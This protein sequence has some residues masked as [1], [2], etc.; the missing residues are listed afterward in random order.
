M[1]ARDGYKDDVNCGLGTDTAYA[2]KLDRVNEDCENVVPGEP[3]P[4][5]PRRR[6]RVLLHCGP[7]QGHKEEAVASYPAS[8]PRYPRGP[9]A[10]DFAPVNV[11]AGWA[12]YK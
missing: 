10:P 6:T 5:T 12:V 8:A 9:Y 4:P 7:R 1:N 11:L 2:D 3:E